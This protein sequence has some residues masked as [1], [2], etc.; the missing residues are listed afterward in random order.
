MVS[1]ERQVCV[2][3]MKESGKLLAGTLKIFSVAL[4]QKLPVALGGA[5]AKEG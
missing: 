1:P 4:H 3:E 5:A 2:G